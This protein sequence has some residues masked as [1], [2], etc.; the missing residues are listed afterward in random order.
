[1][2]RYAI[3]VAGGR[4]VRMGSEVPKQFLMLGGR[5]VLMYCILAFREAVP[6]IPIFVVL[7][8]DHVEGWKV[9]CE[10]IGFEERHAVVVG[11]SSRYESVKNALSVLDRG[12]VLDGISVLDGVSVLDGAGYVAIHDGVRPL[13]HPETIRRLFEEAEMYSCAVPVLT[14]KDS[15]RWEDAEGNRVLDR[16]FV[17]LIQTPQ[18]FELNKLRDAYVQEFEDSFTDDATVWEKAGGTVHLCEG[19]EGN[20]KITTRGDL[21]MV[22]V[23]MREGRSKAEGRGQKAEA[24]EK[25]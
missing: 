16:N 8:E 25:L 22:A 15:V 5:P 24:R 10:E 11:G 23:L 12:S 19:Q 4:G 21:E 7:P 2:E 6:G 1:V 13:I 17:K 20:I 14:P 18:V 3:I 9:L